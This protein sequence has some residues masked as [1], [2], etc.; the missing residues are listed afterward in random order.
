MP[1]GLEALDSPVP[2]GVLGT[3]WMLNKLHPDVYTLDELKAD[4]QAFYSTF[5]G[6]DVD[7]GIFE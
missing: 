5:Y 1:V 4:A 6:F 3:L 7:T 2:S